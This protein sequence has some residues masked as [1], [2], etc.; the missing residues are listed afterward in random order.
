MLYSLQQSTENICAVAEG[1]EARQMSC[2]FYSYCFTVL[3][4]VHGSI[5]AAAAQSTFYF[6]FMSVWYSK[7]RSD[8]DRTAVFTMADFV[9][10]EKQICLP[11][12]VC[13]TIANAT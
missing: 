2:S 1:D 8:D 11:F 10:R 13:D 6:N 5:S 9:V 4:A 3:F 7:M 12:F